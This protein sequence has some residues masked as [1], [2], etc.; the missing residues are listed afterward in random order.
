M[1]VKVSLQ[2]VVR[3]FQMTAPF[4]ARRRLVLAQR[5]VESQWELKEICSSEDRLE[6]VKFSHFSPFQ[7]PGER[8]VIQ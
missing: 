2:E 6:F 1:K 8:T 7:S 5:I 3:N 4:K